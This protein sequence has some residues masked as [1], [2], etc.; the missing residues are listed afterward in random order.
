MSRNAYNVGD[1]VEYGPPTKSAPE[2]Y[3][4]L[5]T[6]GIVTKISKYGIWVRWEGAEMDSQHAFDLSTTRVLVFV[7]QAALKNLWRI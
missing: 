3:R 7:V 1:I 4:N 5:G 6:K 2:S